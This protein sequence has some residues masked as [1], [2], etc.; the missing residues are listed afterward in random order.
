MEMCITPSADIAVILI[1]SETE[2][3]LGQ[4]FLLLTT[5]G[6]FCRIKPTFTSAFH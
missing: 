3:R 4:N 5:T 6:I 2:V 1:K